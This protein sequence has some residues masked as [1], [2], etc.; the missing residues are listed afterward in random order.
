MVLAQATIRVCS[1]ITFG[2]LVVACGA[3]S[4]NGGNSSSTVKINELE[5]TNTVVTDP[6]GKTP[7][8]VEL[9]NTGSEEVD[10]KGYFLSDDPADLDKFTFTTDAVIAAHGTLVVWASGADNVGNGP[11]YAGFKLGSDGDQLNLTDPDGYI[12]DNVQFGTAP[13]KDY[14]YARFPDGT[15]DFAWCAKESHGALNGNACAE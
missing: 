11:L 5:S 14:A 15:G 6:T 3:E 10:L 13:L 4:S 2:L 9:Y 7:D 1:V 8:W 12:V